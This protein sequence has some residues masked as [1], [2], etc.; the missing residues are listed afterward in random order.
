MHDLDIEQFLERSLDLLDAGIAKL[1]D[2]TRVGEDDVVV[3]L[4]A[5]ALLVLGDFFAKLVLA[6]QIAIDEQLYRVVERR[7]A[8]PVF[9]RL[10][11]GKQRLDVEVPVEVVYLLQDGKALRG[12]AVAVLLEVGLEQIADLA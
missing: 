12:L 2:F 8:D 7:T 6:D 11:G 3:L 4:D 5:V 10:H 1:D 9:L